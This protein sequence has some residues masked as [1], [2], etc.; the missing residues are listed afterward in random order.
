MFEMV[1]LAGM[2]LTVFLRLFLDNPISAAAAAQFLHYT[3]ALEHMD[4]SVDREFNCF[5]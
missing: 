1:D 3:V 5:S 2:V 4:F